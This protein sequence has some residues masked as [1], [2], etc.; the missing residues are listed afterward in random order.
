MIPVERG[1]LSRNSPDY[2]EM[3]AEVFVETVRKSVEEAMC[4]G[5]DN[6]EITPSLME[7]LQYVYLHGTSPVRSI[8]WGLDISLSAAS[9]LVDRLVKKDF[10]TRKENDEDRRSMEVGLTDSGR[11][12]VE[13]M[14]KRRSDWF[15]S[16]VRAMPPTK[17]RAFLEGLEAFLK[18]ALA[19]E[20]DIDRACVRCGVQ[21]TPGCVVSKVKSERSRNDEPGL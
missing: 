1:G 18:V 3:I 9:Q 8:A 15:A 12:V 10:A 6:E 5:H 20:G 11:E 13:E 7:C 14:R 16:I 2:A 19:L 21:H 17:R 4:C